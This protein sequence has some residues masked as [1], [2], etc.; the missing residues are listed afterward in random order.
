M[1]INSK[2]ECSICLRGKNVVTKKFTCPHVFH[3]ICI[4]GWL[5]KDRSCPVCRNTIFVAKPVTFQFGVIALVCTI[6]AGI[7]LIR[8]SFLGRWEEN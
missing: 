1:Q 6:A 7:F 3:K 8:K 5:E 2:E 4:E